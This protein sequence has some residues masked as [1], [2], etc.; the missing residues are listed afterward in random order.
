MRKWKKSINDEM[1]VADALTKV[2]DTSILRAAV[3]AGIA[4]YKAMP[5]PAGTW[6]K[7]GAK[8]VLL[9]AIGASHIGRVA[10]AATPDPDRSSATSPWVA[11]GLTLVLS[12]AAMALAAWALTLRSQAE[13]QRE[14]MDKLQ[15][16]ME[17]LQG[18]PPQQ[19]PLAA[20]HPPQA[21]PAAQPP[22]VLQPAAVEL[23]M[24]N[25]GTQSQMTYT[26]WRRTPRFVASPHDGEVDIG[27]VWRQH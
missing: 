27:R 24:R 23:Y 8:A 7:G 25:M 12:L 4:V 13:T 14:A 15:W 10:G 26:R 21:A 20:A 22:A 16:A 17:K 3:S 9:A 1:L 6:T 5:K 18:M 19:A 2:M 11:L